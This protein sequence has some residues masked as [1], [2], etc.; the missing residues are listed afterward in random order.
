MYGQCWD[1]EFHVFA[2][3]ASDT[4][5]LPLE[6]VRPRCSAEFLAKADLEIEQVRAYYAEK[7][8]EACLAVLSKHRCL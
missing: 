1:T 3:I 5:H 2:L 4:D 6:H 7:V 8:R